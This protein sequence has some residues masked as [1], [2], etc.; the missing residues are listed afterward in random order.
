MCD[1]SPLLRELFAAYLKICE[2]S[3]R[4]DEKQNYTKIFRKMKICKNMYLFGNEPETSLELG[5]EFFG[6]AS[7]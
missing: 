2:P 7:K 5:K 1:I 3:L 4:N 6:I